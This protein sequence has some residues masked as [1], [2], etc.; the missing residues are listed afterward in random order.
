MSSN[1]VPSPAAV[2]T[3]VFTYAEFRQL[4]R[5]LA[6]EHRTSGPDQNPAYVRFTDQNQ[7]HLDRALGEPLLPELVGR[8]THLAR[9]EQWLVLGEAWCGDTAHTLPVLAHLADVSAGHVELR[10][11]LRS[12]HP[13]L[14]A[15]HQTNGGNSIPKLI[16]RDAATGADLGD[17]G[18]R[19]AEA[20]ALAHQLHADKTL[21]TNQIIKAMN[22][23]YEDDHGAAVQ[24]ELLALVG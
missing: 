1:F 5:T 3:P 17:W 6:A 4:V 10:V 16:R 15:A 19:P 14:M 18:P 12:D 21:H 13:A 23:W 22:A 9:P 7:A 2:P 20:Q 24:R 11:L 8:L